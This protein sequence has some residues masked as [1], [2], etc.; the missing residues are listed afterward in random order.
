MGCDVCGYDSPPPVCSV[1]DHVCYGYSCVCNGPCYGYTNP[2]KYRVQIDSIGSIDTFKWSDD[3]GSTWDVSGIQITGGWQ[4]LNN[5][6]K[7]RFDEVSGHTLTD[8]WDF[9]AGDGIFLGERL[10]YYY[11]NYGGS[12]DLASQYFHHGA[13][14]QN[15]DSA[16]K[17]EVM[18][19]N[20]PLR[21]TAYSYI[22]LTYDANAWKGI[23]D[24]TATIKGR[25]LFDPR[26]GSTKFSRN[27][28]LV[29]MDFLTNM[30]YG[31]GVPVANV[32]LQSVMDVANWCDSHG[33]YYDGVIMDRQPFIDNFE[34]IMLNFRAFTVWSEGVY[35]LK[36]F[37][38]DASVLSLT[39]A[40]IEIS[41]E[42]FT[43]KIPG[44]P[45]TPNMAKMIFADKTSNYTT[46]YIQRE[47]LNQISY[48]GE[49]RIKELTLKGTTA[50]IQAQKLAK[51]CLLR[52]R[53]NKE[54]AILGHLRCFALE[55]GDMIS[56]THEFPG[57]TNKKLRVKDVAYPQQGLVP[58][59]LMEE[60][61]S[62]YDEAI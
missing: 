42:S 21:Y 50:I 5:G 6:V 16:L 8:Y 28:A 4:D 39:D 52:N 61:S 35:Y 36:T 56:I 31:L 24:A 11:K 47:D 3:G 44:V 12:S 25:K 53:F 14:D 60:D 23:P 33:F 30:R 13:V 58:L 45:E 17:N 49:P 34:E 40:D 29:W 9:W 43:I 26:D 59:A 1:C 48:D 20:E 57:W 51:Y 41:P 38:D 27:P 7:V 54:F 2:T 19:W 10:I 32:N 18:E 15:V 22:R 37:S 46:Q 55:P 62:I